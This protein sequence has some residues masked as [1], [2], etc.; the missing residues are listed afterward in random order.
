MWCPQLWS[1]LFFLMLLTLGLDSQVRRSCDLP[2]YI[3]MSV[4]RSLS[5]IIYLCLKNALE[6]SFQLFNRSLLVQ[7]YPIAHN[8]Y[9]IDHHFQSAIL[10]PCPMLLPFFPHI[11]PPLHTLLHPNTTSATHPTY[12]TYNLRY[13]PFFTHIQPPLHTL[14]TPRTTSATHPTY[15]TYN[16][17][18][19]P[20]LPHVHRTTSACSHPLAREDDITTSA[21]ILPLAVCRGRESDDRNR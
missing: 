15:P 14:P 8:S 7:L 13:T 3:A 21:N 12:P 6:P 17:R 16:L 1:V 11:Q 5:F 2:S 18:Y 9:R 19:I 10:N 4:H 20:Y